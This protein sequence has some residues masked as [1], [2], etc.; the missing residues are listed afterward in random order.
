MS[1]KQ[2]ISR[3]RNINSYLPLMEQD[4][5]GLT[6]KELIAEVITPN[7]PKPWLTNFKL[8]ELNRKT[9][10]KDV[11]DKLVVME[12][13][14]KFEKKQSNQQGGNKLKNPCRLHNGTHEWSECRQNPKNGGNGGNPQKT[15]EPRRCK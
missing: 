2:W 14:I 6:E 4:A 11:L 9:I 15:N 13:T 10:I 3:M 7:L 1:V 8:L 5:V 12:E